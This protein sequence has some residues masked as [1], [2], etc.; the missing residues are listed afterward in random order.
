MTA[1]QKI[2]LMIAG[3]QKSGTTSLKNY[4]GQHPAIVTHLQ[5]EFSFFM[6]P[7]EYAAGIKNAFRKYFP[8]QSVATQ[9]VVAK[10]A[11]LYADEAALQR[12]HA[13]NPKCIVVLLLRN[14]VQRA[15]SS[16]MME[17]NSGWTDVEWP[18]IINSVEKFKVGEKDQMFRLFIELGM[19]AQHLKKILRFFPREQVMLIRFEDFKNNPAAIC[20][21]VIERLRLDPFEI[22]SSQ[23]F[24]KAYEPRSKRMAQIL[25]R[26]SYETNPVKRFV[27]TVLPLT[28]YERW[29]QQLLRLNRGKPSTTRMDEE[30]RL[31]LIEF[32]KPYN[33]ELEQLTG[34]SFSDWNS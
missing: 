24:N 17:V 1:D 19:Y 7:Q 25:V 13:L 10:A 16:F 3:A 32:F 2:D 5:T 12:L 26:L 4:L 23:T 34:M 20:S 33:L 27:K 31:K 28:L 9:R 21:S 14:P 15:Y 22:E 18:A 29:S 6:R 30:V 8:A 11:G